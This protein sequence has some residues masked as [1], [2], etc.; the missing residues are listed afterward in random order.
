MLMTYLSFFNKEDTVI[1]GDDLGEIPPVPENFVIAESGDVEKAKERWKATL[2]W[3]RDNGI[4]RIL[5]VM[6]ETDILN[7]YTESRKGFINNSII[8]IG[9]LVCNPGPIT[10]SVHPSPQ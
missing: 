4:N 5:Q 6:S 3:R 7:R 8:Q 9:P 10:I 2:R 1:E